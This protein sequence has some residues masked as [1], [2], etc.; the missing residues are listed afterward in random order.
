[1]SSGQRQTLGFALLVTLSLAALGVA[2]AAQR[3]A[4]AKPQPGVA[5]P[6]LW[7]ATHSRGLVDAGTEVRITALLA[8]LSV[9]ENFATISAA[10][11]LLG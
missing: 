10:L 1:M 5:H 11:T 2:T 3:R 4:A 8:R 9:D 7:P 6:Q